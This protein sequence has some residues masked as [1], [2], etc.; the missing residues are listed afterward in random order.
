LTTKE[1]RAKH[2]ILGLFAIA[3]SSLSQ[4]SFADQSCT[5]DCSGGSC[6]ICI[7]ACPKNEEKSAA[8]GERQHASVNGTGFVV[9]G[10]SA[11]LL[12]A[13][14]AFAPIAMDVLKAS[15]GWN[16]IDP[17]FGALLNQFRSDVALGNYREARNGYLQLRQ[18]F[19]ARDSQVPE[20]LN[21]IADGHSTDKTGV[22]NTG[23]ICSCGANGTRFCERM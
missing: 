7:G 15:D 14:S 5:A 16:V 11:D 21:R 23:V 12:R 19:I 3:A 10:S 13:Q 22:G 9:V 6:S 18:Q 2:V 17:E 4:P 20:V 1:P 8:R